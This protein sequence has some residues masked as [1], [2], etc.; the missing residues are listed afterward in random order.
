MKLVTEDPTKTTHQVL[1]RVLATGEYKTSNNHKTPLRE[2]RRIATWNVNGLL[3]PG[4]LE[5]VEK[6]A[7]THEINILGIAKTYMHGQGH[8]STPNG[9]SLES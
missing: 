6:E 3:A 9:S 7:E 8:F 4:K 1:D 2:H 5:F